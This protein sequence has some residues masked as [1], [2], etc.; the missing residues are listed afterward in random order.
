MQAYMDSL[1][2]IS[3]L[4]AYEINTKMNDGKI[5][6]RGWKN[7]PVQRMEEQSIANCVLK[8]GLLHKRKRVKCTSLRLETSTVQIN[9]A[10]KGHLQ[11]NAQQ[12]NA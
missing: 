9:T 3:C 2:N 7:K 8:S 4:T 11:T 5:M 10:M 1:H 6:T 12:F